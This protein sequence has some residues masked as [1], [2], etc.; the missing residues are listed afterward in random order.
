MQDENRR[1]SN[2]RISTELSRGPVMNFNLK[3]ETICIQSQPITD[4]NIHTISSM[5][6]QSE[7]L[8][9]INYDIPVQ[10]MVNIYNDKLSEIC[11]SVSPVIIKNV[12]ERSQ[13]VW[14]TADLQTLKREKRKAERKFLKIKSYDNKNNYKEKCSTYYLRI[15]EARTRA[16]IHRDI[17]LTF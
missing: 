11:N 8:L 17:N 9:S 13:Q 3:N 14:Y 12:K 5:I 2:Q 16:L 15:K 7:E 4:E 1:L 6:I 10:D